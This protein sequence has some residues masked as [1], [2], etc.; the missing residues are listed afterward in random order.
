[1]LGDCAHDIRFLTKPGTNRVLST[2]APALWM[3]NSITNRIQVSQQADSAV[4]V[5]GYG[6]GRFWQVVPGPTQN[7]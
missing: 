3:N 5:D 7:K 4:M 1:M 2:V 6:F